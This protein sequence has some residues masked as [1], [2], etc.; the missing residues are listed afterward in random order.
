MK[1]CVY[2]LVS[3]LFCLA[4]PLRA[5]GSSSADG[6]GPTAPAA[7]TLQK[8][9]GSLEILCPPEVATVQTS[10]AAPEGWDVFIDTVNAKHFLESISLY[11]GHPRE[12]ASLVPDNEGDSSD[13]SSVWTLFPE[14]SRSYWVACKYHDTDIMLIKSFAITKSCIVTANPEVNTVEVDCS[15]NPPADDK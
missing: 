13:D 15:A 7:G 2:L 14:N 1:F 4:A 12:M 8:K 10:S 6:S 3:A 5:Q 9:A 11:S